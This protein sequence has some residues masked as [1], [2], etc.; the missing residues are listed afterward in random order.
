MWTLLHQHVQIANL[1]CFETVV[2]ADFE[3]VA[4]EIADG[5][6]HGRDLVGILIS[7]AVPRHVLQH[8]AGLGVDEE[9]FDA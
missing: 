1:Q 2:S 9:L 7:H 4:H 6:Q 8:E 3:R 5:G